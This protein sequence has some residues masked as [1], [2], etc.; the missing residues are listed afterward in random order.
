MAWKS[1]NPLYNNIE[2]CILQNRWAVLAG[3]DRLCESDLAYRWLCGGVALNHHGLS[4]FRVDHAEVLDRLLS[5]SLAALLAEGVVKLDEVA[6]DGTK[7]KA[8]AGRGSFRR[9]RTLALSLGGR[10]V[11]ADRLIA[12]SA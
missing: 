1:Q 6:I 5:E 3:L 7:V 4:D 12:H 9:E 8:C 2:Q 11:W 10:E